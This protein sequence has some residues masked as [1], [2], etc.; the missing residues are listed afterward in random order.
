MNYKL[1]AHLAITAAVCLAYPEIASACG[2]GPGSTSFSMSQDA[3]DVYATATMSLGGLGCDGGDMTATITA[4]DSTTASAETAVNADYSDYV[5]T[6]TKAIG[7]LDG[8]YS[9][10]GTYWWS[11]DPASCGNPSSG[12]YP[13]GQSSQVVNPFVRITSVSLSSTT[14]SKQ[15]GHI[16]YT[17]SLLVS[18]SCGGSANLLGALSMIPANM[19]I[20]IGP[21]SGSSYTLSQNITPGNK[22][23][24]FAIST[25]PGNQVSG[26]P[27]HV[28]SGVTSAPCNDKTTI[29]TDL[30]FTVSP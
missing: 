19:A 22:D 23:F 30:N 6:A 8:T 27:V 3:V 9:G 28:S 4:P 2:C 7:T 25:D 12:Y 17:A 1:L 16:N 21:N 18:D 26:G 14:I 20:Y 15:M 10:S 13:P 29:N 11:C 5:V 24:V